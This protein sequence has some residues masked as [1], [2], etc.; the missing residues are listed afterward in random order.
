MGSTLWSAFYGLNV[1]GNWHVKSLNLEQEVGSDD[2][3]ILVSP[4]NLLCEC[5]NVN[6]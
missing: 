6:Y 3:L 4:N 5:L 2:L 1:H